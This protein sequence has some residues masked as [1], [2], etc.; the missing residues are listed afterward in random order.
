VPLVHWAARDGV[1]HVTLERPPANALGEPLLEGLGAALTEFEDGP[2]KVAVF[3]SAIAGFF[4][5]GAD[6]KHMASLMPEGFQQ[7]GDDLRAC[8]E[9]VAAC[10]KP[11][12][13]A[14][15]GLA[16]GG[17][18]E[19]A[20]A[21]S[22]RFATPRSRLGIPEIKLGLVPGAGGTQR[23]PRLVGR[24]RALLM[25][26]TGDEVDGAEAARI[27][28]VD[29]LV[30]GDVAEAALAVATKMA[31]RSGPALAALL[32]LADAADEPLAEGLA[33]EARAVTRLFAD[34][35]GREGLTAFVAKRLPVFE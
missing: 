15:D 6:I 21:C 34:G 17:G 30:D 26:L 8:L 24:G 10:P 27:G 9:R 2:A 25:S 7:Y 22:L 31:R 5:A 16:L 11:S 28:L 3:T 19:L 4:A 35:E 1:L 14:I 20:C 18:L 23:L 12:I 33:I 13:A 32:E 29:V